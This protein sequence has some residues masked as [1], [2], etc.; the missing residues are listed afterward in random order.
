MITVKESEAEEAEWEIYVK[1]MRQPCRR[2]KKY[3][4]GAS[5]SGLCFNCHD[6]MALP[7]ESGEDYIGIFS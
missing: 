3:F 4:E 1:A 2:C 7:Y 6:L 5:W